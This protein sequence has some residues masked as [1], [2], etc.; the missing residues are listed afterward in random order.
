MLD[1]EADYREGEDIEEEV[2]DEELVATGDEE[3][4]EYPY[5]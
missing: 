4:E 1:E 2:E 5:A 3:Y